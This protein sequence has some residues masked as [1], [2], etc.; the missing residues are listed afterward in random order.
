M[1]NPRPASLAIALGANLGD[2]LTTL[3]AVRPLLAA[4]LAATAEAAGL[5]ADRLHCRWSPL[6]RTAP[7]GG[8]P[9][10]PPY[11]NA[12]LVATA[13]HH[14]SA[15]LN[16]LDPRDLLQRLQALER[17]FGRVRVEHW[18]PRH[19]DL[20]L[21]W[22]GEARQRSAELSLPHP[23]LQQRSFV[24]APLA[25][26][27]PALVPQGARASASLLLATLLNR[28]GEVPPEALPGRSGWP[29]QRPDWD[30]PDPS[31]GAAATP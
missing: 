18:G 29:E 12:A 30:L 21:L 5:A 4:S 13:E 26:I 28:P 3:L 23:L 17:R 11:L 16:R 8:P 31:H 14:P 10:Q 20:D 9:G 25:A 2:P 1:K 6:F 22:C 19:L 27:D 7:V 24:L 15:S